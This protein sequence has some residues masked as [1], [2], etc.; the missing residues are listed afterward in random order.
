MMSLDKSGKPVKGGT[1]IVVWERKGD[2]LEPCVM[3]P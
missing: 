3:R 1:K 2:A